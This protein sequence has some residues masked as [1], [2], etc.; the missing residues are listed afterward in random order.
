MAEARK[1][2][3]EIAEVLA[4]TELRQLLDEYAEPTT[5]AWGRRWHCPVP[6]HPDSHASVTIHVDAR[7][8]ERWRCW[9]GD[10]THR[11]DAID[12]VMVAHRTDRS[13]AIDHLAQRAGMHLGQ[14]LPPPVPRKPRRPAGPVPLRPEVRSYVDACANHLWHPDMIRVRQWLASRGFTKQTLIENR[15]GADPGRLILRRRKGLPRGESVAAT[16]PAFDEQG[17]VTYVQS[18]YLQPQ[19]DGPKYE[20]PVQSFGSNPRV[21]WPKP[22]GADRPGVLVVC[23]G[24][25]DA[26][27]AA[28]GGFAAAGILGSQ[29]PDETIAAALASHAER[30]DRAIVAVVDGDDAG[31]HWGER[32]GELISTTGHDLH[33]IEP[34]GVGCDLNDW[35]LSDPDWASWIAPGIGSAHDVVS[36]VE[37]QTPPSIE[38]PTP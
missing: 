6:D 29:A 33:L 13:S 2:R 28:Q 19:P 9:S 32:L 12:L 30:H 20:N 16:F 5:T 26:L 23:E 38:M 7:G 8:H 25:P 11:G 14:P 17:A 34:P 21:A 35:A 15:I 10:D 1:P 18:R 3:F 24:I 31:R 22:T 36:S 37:R 27:I 4:R